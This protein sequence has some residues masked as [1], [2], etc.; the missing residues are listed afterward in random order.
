MNQSNHDT[1]H[2]ILTFG[3]TCERT[4]RKEKQLWDAQLEVVNSYCFDVYMCFKR[5]VTVAILE[6]EEEQ[7]VTLNQTNNQQTKQMFM[8]VF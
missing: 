1:A 6:K 2:D 3:V 8:R 7:I 5:H 4:G